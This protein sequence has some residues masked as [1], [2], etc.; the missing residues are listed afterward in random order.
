MGHSGGREVARCV[1]DDDALELKKAFA[2]RFTLPTLAKN[3]RMGHPA[4]ALLGGRAVAIKGPSI[5]E[6]KAGQPDRRHYRGDAL[7][8]GTFVQLSTSDWPACS[9]SGVI[10]AARSF[11]AFSLCLY[12][13]RLASV[14]HMYALE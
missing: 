4:V 8:A 7:F 2:A 10:L 1:A 5:Q 14:Y 3:A 11:R 13:P 6:A 12:P 9:C